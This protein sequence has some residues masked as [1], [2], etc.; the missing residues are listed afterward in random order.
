M[1][2]FKLLEVVNFCSLYYGSL[3][4]LAFFFSVNL[5]SVLLLLLL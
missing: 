1:F 5:L 2:H 4:S 3:H